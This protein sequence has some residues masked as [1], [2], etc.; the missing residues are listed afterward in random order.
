[1]T[2]KRALGVASGLALTAGFALSALPAQAAPIDAA[3][4]EAAVSWKLS[5]PARYINTA[6]H[7]AV[8]G[9]SDAKRTLTI[10][11]P[12]V[13]NVEAGDRWQVFSAGGYVSAEGTF[14][15]GEAAAGEDSDVIYVEKPGSNSVAGDEKNVRVRINDAE[16]ATG[17]GWEVDTDDV[18]DLVLLRRTEFKSGSSA[19]RVNFSPEP[20]VDTVKASGKLVRAN[21][22]T[23]K[24]VGYEGRNAHTQTR[25]DVVG[26]AYG[27]VGEI[28]TGAG[29][30]FVF[31]F[32]VSDPGAPAP[33]EPFIGRGL[34]NGNATSG[35]TVST[36]D[37]VE[38]ADPS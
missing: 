20:Y 23:G 2:I 35:G 14:T 4:C 29:G 28:S 26:S 19:D 32:K 36:G 8:I 5:S 10:K 1:M 9:V 16:S 21:W 17:T 7:E 25:T 38:P 6:D 11:A 3:A 30:A 24:Y 34:Y 27:D 18:G 13:C 37:R 15:A 12:A 33:G 31:T 22:S